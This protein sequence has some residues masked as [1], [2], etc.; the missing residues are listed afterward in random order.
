ML[1]GRW[2][3]EAGL[4]C[5]PCAGPQATDLSWVL[6]SRVLE[7]AQAPLVSR[8]PWPRSLAALP[9]VQLPAVPSGR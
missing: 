9:Q 1:R 7:G 4:D 5:H 8:A 2:L 6:T 3:P